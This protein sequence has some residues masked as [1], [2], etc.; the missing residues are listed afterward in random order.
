MLRELLI[1]LE[2][3]LAGKSHWN[4]LEYLYDLVPIP[5]LRIPLDYSC[6][7]VCYYLCL[8]GG[9]VDYE[10]VCVAE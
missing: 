4:W 9:V 6:F 7:F 5:I 8:L 1:V 3:L 10:I 2:R